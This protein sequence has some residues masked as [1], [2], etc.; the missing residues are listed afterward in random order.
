MLREAAAKTAE[1]LA[2]AQSAR[3]QEQGDAAGRLEE[4]RAAAAKERDELV[5]LADK[6]SGGWGK[7]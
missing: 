5:A 1:E 4:A 3:T 6:V 2:T 7:K